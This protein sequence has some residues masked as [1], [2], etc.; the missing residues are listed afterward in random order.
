PRC[1]VIRLARVP[2]MDITGLQ[3]LEEAIDNLQR[4][5]VRVILCEAN[6]RVLLKLTRAH[7]VRRDE[8]PPRYFRSLADAVAAAGNQK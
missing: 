7:I 6:Q 2:F 5:K 3:T 1:I 8:H 4:R